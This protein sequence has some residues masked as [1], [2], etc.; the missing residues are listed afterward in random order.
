ME[1]QLVGFCVWLCT[2]CFFSGMGI[3]I[4][5]SKKKKAFGFWAN[6]D[7]FPVENVRAY[8]R[9][10]G[11]LWIVFGM[12]FILLGLSLLKGQNSLWILLSILGAMLE[13][14]GCMVVYILVIER[15]YR[16]K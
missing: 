10:L 1:E 2:G 11:K 4:F 5:L 9:A 15:K 12:I 16:K 14:I 6:E 8:N 7:T 13:A 3:Y